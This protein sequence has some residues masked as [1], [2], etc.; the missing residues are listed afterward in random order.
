MPFYAHIVREWL[1]TLQV[2]VQ[3]KHFVSLLIVA[4]LLHMQFL[5]LWRE[6]F[7]GAWRRRIVSFFRCLHRR[8]SRWSS[9]QD[10]REMVHRNRF[11]I[12]KPAAPTVRARVPFDLGDPQHKFCHRLYCHCVRRR[13]L[14]R[15][16]CCGQ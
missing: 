12:G 14:Q 16:T 7:P 10:V 2:W 11:E 6:G 15:P 3:G 1:G 8:V 9:R 5:A 4:L 13:H